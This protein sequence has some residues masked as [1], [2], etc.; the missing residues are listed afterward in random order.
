MNESPSIENVLRNKSSFKQSFFICIWDRQGCGIV[1]VRTKGEGL[2]LDVAPAQTG[3]S[4][5]QVSP[6]SCSPS[7]LPSSLTQGHRRTV[8]AL[9][10]NV[11]SQSPQREQKRWR[12]LCTSLR[13]LMANMLEGWCQ[14]LLWNSYSILSAFWIEIFSKKF[15]IR[16]SQWLDEIVSPFCYRVVLNTL[17]WICALRGTSVIFTFG[18]IPKV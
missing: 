12:N 16:S 6:S 1:Q 13:N 5:R 8:P 2:G 18:F 15:R 4:P 7:S 11:G 14:F 17:G 10:L 3:E 9:A